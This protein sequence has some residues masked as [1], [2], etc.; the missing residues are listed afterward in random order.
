MSAPIT[1]ADATALWRAVEA[2]REQFRAMKS[3]S[4]MAEHLP[5][6]QAELKAASTALRKVQA[7]V[8]AEKRGGR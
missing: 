7:Q 4:G 1:K 2:M 8:R 5:A 3:M 6:A